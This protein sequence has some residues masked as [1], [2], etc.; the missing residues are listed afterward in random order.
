MADTHTKRELEVVFLRLTKL[1]VVV[2]VEYSRSGRH[3]VWH[4]CIKKTL[5]SVCTVHVGV[6][7]WAPF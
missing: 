2:H 5:L 1:E 4:C 7:I 6:L 3:R